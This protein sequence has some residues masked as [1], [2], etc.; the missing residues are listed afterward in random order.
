MEI[1]D[2]ALMN[3][4]EIITISRTEYENL[5]HQVEQLTAQLGAVNSAENITI[6]NTEYEQLKQQIN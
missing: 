2:K 3:N 5:Q 1:N 4:D 6:P